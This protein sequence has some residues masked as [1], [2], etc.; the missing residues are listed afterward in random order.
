MVTDVVD[1]TDVASVGGVTDEVV[2][3]E[4]TTGNVEFVVIFAAFDFDF[5]FFF[6]LFLRA[7][8]A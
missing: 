3:E 4:C 7:I 8:L 2:E 1:A 5:D 6:L